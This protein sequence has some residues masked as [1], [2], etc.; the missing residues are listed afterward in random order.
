MIDLIFQSRVNDCQ[1]EDFMSDDVAPTSVQRQD[2]KITKMVAVPSAKPESCPDTSEWPD[3]CLGISGDAVNTRPMSALAIGRENGTV[4]VF[5]EATG[6]AVDY[7][8]VQPLLP[9]FLFGFFLRYYYTLQSS[10]LLST[11]TAVGTLS[12]QWYST[13]FV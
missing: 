5:L 9:V 8:Q 2:C 7:Y 4:A 13:Y 1:R 3:S 11:Y 10:T 12:I 6:S